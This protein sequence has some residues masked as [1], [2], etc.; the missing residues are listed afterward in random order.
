MRVVDNG[1]VEE[2]FIKK[3]EIGERWQAEKKRSSLCLYVSVMV[4]A[5][6]QKIRNSEQNAKSIFSAAAGSSLKSVSMRVF[7]DS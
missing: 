3:K 5:I 2:E 1:V 4:A 7:I 6:V